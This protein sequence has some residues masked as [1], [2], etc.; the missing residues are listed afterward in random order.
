MKT[1]KEISLGYDSDSSGGNLSDQGSDEG[2]ESLPTYPPI[3]LFIGKI[4]KN[5]RG[6]L[7]LH[8]IFK[9]VFKLVHNKMPYIN[10][11]SKN[12]QVELLQVAPL[13]SHV[14]SR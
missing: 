9:E 13:D 11:N 12:I 4:Q 5:E 7:A 2:A 3:A 8:S 14:L 6:F 10:L 1:V